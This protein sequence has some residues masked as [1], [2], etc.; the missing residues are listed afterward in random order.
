M[1][2]RAIRVALPQVASKGLVSFGSSGPLLVGAAPATGKG[3]PSS[4]L[5]PAGPALTHTMFGIGSPATMLIGAQPFGGG[6]GR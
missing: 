1:A 4:P 5:G 2:G 3:S 6:Q